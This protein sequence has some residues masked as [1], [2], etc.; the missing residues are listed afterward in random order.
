MYYLLLAVAAIGHVILWTACVN[1][2][3]GLGMN[4][5]LIDAGTA[6]SGLMLALAPIAIAVRIWQHPHASLADGSFLG[7]LA[8]LYIIACAL[9]CA[10]AAVHRLWLMLHPERGGVLLANHTHQEW[11]SHD[12]LCPRCRAEW[13]LLAAARARLEGEA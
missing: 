9:F 12:R 11:T 4:R 5:R 3:H 13:R 2:L 1:R 8:S 7:S 6:A 10:G